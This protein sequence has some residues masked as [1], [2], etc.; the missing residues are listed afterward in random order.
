MIV[1]CSGRLSFYRTT[2]LAAI[3][4]HSELNYFQLPVNRLGCHLA[5]RDA[6]FPVVPDSLE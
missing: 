1:T 3:N 2:L 4:T 5:M 6:V